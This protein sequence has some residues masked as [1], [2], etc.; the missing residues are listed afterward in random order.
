[1]A[2]RLLHGAYLYPVLLAVLAVTSRYR[3]DHAW[4]FW[5]A[6]LA[7]AAG[8]GLRGLLAGMGPKAGSLTRTTFYVL[9]S[10]AISLPSGAVG[11]LCAGAL[12]FY[13]LESWELVISMLWAVGLAAGISTSFAPSFRLI[14]L[15]VL[16]LLAPP[17]MEG[18]ALG[19]LE[20]VAFGACAG[21]MAAF[22]LGQGSRLHAG[23][24]E[25]LRRRVQEAEH[26]RELEAARAA[27]EAA[28]QT[29]SRFLAM[30]SHEVRTPLHGILGM[31]QIA[32]A[33]PT[34]DEM[35][36]HVKMLVNSGESLL[37]VLNDILDFSKYEAGKLALEQ[38]PFSLR[39]L[40]GGCEINIAPQASAKRLQWEIYV[41]DD[42]PDRFLGDPTRLRQVLL[43]LMG[44]AVKFT[45]SGMVNLEVSR[46][47]EQADRKISLLFEISDTGV[48]IPEDQRA[49]IFDAFS[50]ADSSVTRRFG[51]TGLGLTISS[52]LVQLMG[53]RIWVESVPG[54][55]SR[56]FFT[57]QFQVHE[58]QTDA[59]PAEVAWSAERLL[60]VL[61]AE[62]NVVNQ[63]VALA[64]LEKRGHTTKVV[65][66]GVEAVEAWETGNFDLI[67]MD[68]HMPEMS[69]IEAAAIIRR[70]EAA[71]GRP[72]TPIVAITASA[73]K[74]DR[75]KL[76]E[77][78][79]DDHLAKP[80]RAQDLYTAIAQAT[81]NRPAGGKSAGPRSDG[82]A[83]TS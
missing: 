53:G 69:G 13:G 35:R 28:N 52:Q 50:Q 29:K 54:E 41:D 42:V 40:I 9:A 15:A 24:W 73:M 30:M 18:L 21:L 32:L 71:A 20:G 74:G 37:Q 39:E 66:T 12:R 25:Q 51:G 72:R 17:V 58:G 57:A 82:A 33:C 83:G 55:G 70:K 59:A 23:Y 49:L 67:L 80:F 31:S 7:M 22:L 68:N 11:F 45:E 19:T 56:F 79:M 64:L 6:A 63:K 14:Q 4:S 5:G 81:E 3:E 2:R 38:T 34:A 61:L 65:T 10:L 44:N 75:E 36:P 76:L 47:T 48:G 77:A 43:N 27:A 8:I 16:F 26:S 1:M 62:D 78:G 46:V 60:R